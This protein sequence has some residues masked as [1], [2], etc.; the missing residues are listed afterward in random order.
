MCNGSF[1]RSGSQRQDSRMRGVATSLICFLTIGVMG[2]GDNAPAEP[3]AAVVQP[4]AAEPDAASP[5]AQPPVECPAPAAGAIGGACR[6]SSECDSALGTG[7]G[8]CLDEAVVNGVTNWPA[9]GYC[10]RTCS[11]TSPCPAGASCLDVGGGFLACLPDCCEQETCFDG[12]LCQDNL[13]GS[14]LPDA[15]ACVPGNAAAADGDPCTDFGDCNRSSVCRPDPLVFPGGLCATINCTVGDDSTCSGGRCLDLDQG[16]PGGGVCFKSC[17]SSADCR[18]AE[19]YYCRDDT[20]MGFGKYCTHAEAGDT[21]IADSDCGIAPWTCRT[22]AQSF[23]G[24]YCTVEA[25]PTP[26]TGAGCPQGS[27]VSVCHQP[28]TGPNF[29]ARSCQNNPSICRAGYT[30][31]QIP[32]GAGMV[33][34]CLPT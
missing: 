18:Q 9:V 31:T 26:G 30:C 8:L 20:A 3:D 16:G 6:A 12:M 22:S 28:A 27:A 11:E 17:D 7:D 14:P 23:P 2:C 4:D 29:C 24:G 25:C 5:D 19:G 33:G 13:I 32:S 21:C 34:V 1:A 15:L 10:T